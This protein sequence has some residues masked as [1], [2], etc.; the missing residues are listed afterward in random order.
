[1]LHIAQTTSFDHGSA[2]P[3]GAIQVR[4]AAEQDIELLINA[5]RFGSSVDTFSDV[6]PKITVV[7]NRSLAFGGSGCLASYLGEAARLDMWV[8]PYQ[9][10]LNQCVNKRGGI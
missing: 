1:M 8:N 2:R 3:G 10:A 4:Q 6:H 7:T 5:A 9:E